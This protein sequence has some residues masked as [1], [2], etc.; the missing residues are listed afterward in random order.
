MTN[1]AESLRRTTF[2]ARGKTSQEKDARRE[3]ARSARIAREAARKRRIAEFVAQNLQPT[4]QEVTKM[5]RAEARAS[6]S[7][8]TKEWSIEP[9]KKN[10]V[11]RF[12]IEKHTA[13]RD[14]VAMHFAE[15][16][17]DIFKYETRQY[18]VHHD[19]TQRPSGDHIVGLTV[20]WD[21]SQ[22]S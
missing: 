17:F 18:P 6:N 20:S 2:K 13:L 7:E 4:L 3:A 22:E 9:A 1:L 16:G 8:V 12:E 19:Y 21:E 14:Q 5:A 11:P 10:R 15:M